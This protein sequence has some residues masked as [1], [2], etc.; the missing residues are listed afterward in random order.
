MGFHMVGELQSLGDL[1]MAAARI[2]EAPRLVQAGYVLD[3]PDLPLFI[4]KKRN[5][6]K[7]KGK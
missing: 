4:T 7:H 3:G 2:Q 6:K 1:H 5:M